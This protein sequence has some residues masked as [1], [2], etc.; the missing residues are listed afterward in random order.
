MFVAALAAHLVVKVPVA[1]RAYRS[2]GVLAPLRAELA[3]TEPEPDGDLVAPAPDAPTISRRGLLA[4]GRGR[5]AGARGR[6]RRAVDRRAAAAGSRSSR[7]RRGRAASRSTRPRGRRGITPAMTGAAYRLALRRAAG[8]GSAEPRAIC[9]R[10]RSARHSLPIGCVEGWSTTQEWTGVPLRELARSAGVD[11][12][13]RGRVRVAPAARRARQATLNGRPGRRRATRCWR[14][15]STARDLSPDHGYPARII[16]PALPGVHNTKWVGRDGVPGMRARYGA[17]PL[18]LLAHLALLAAG[19]VGAAAD[20]STSAR[21]ERIVLWLVGARRAP[22][23]RPAAVL[24]ACSTGSRDAAARSAARQL[25]ADPARR[26]PRCCCWCSSRRSAGQRRA[27]TTRASR[28]ASRA[29]LARWLLVSAALFAIA[30]VALPGRGQGRVSR[31]EDLKHA[32]RPCPVTETRP[33]AQVDGDACSAGA[34][35]GNRRRTVRAAP[36]A[37]LG[38][39]VAWRSG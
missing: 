22:R 26:C 23:P 37:Q 28:D 7:P 14:C 20:R 30:G 18:H 36:A 11:R 38:E 27:P 1:L 8:R 16:V 3:E 25:R 21:A 9:W 31:V 34:T 5:V 24:H 13:A 39:L 19:R 29:T 35:A 10:C 15:A 4:V 12:A 6:E 2:R 33:R 17:S 32:V